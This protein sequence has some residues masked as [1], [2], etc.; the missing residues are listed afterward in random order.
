MSHYVLPSS[1][2]QQYT[3]RTKFS[4]QGILTTMNAI[5]SVQGKAWFIYSVVSC[6]LSINHQNCFIVV[7]QKCWR[8]LVLLVYWI[9]KCI[10]CRMSSAITCRLN[11]LYSKWQYQ[12][13][14]CYV[15]IMVIYYLLSTEYTSNEEIKNLGSVYNNKQSMEIH[16]HSL[17]LPMPTL[18]TTPITYISSYH[19]QTTFTQT[20]TLTHS[21]SNTH[22]ANTV[23]RQNY[24]NVVEE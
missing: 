22:S 9:F 16:L 10:S 3:K 20:H 14:F 24:I 6:T 8:R 5:I 19:N 17:V 15:K 18:S 2:I 13:L 7:N 1:Y 4:I 23:L 12:Y 11:L 21:R